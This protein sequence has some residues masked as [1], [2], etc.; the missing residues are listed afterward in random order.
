MNYFFTFQRL[1]T[2]IFSKPTKNPEYD[3]EGKDG[4]VNP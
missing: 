2:F 1:E 4:S 3:R